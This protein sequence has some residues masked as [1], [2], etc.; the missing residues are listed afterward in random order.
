MLVQHLCYYL[1]DWNGIKPRQE[2]WDTNKV[3]KCLKGEPIKGYAQVTV[4]G[5]NFRLEERNRQGFLDH[6]WSA[7]GRSFSSPNQSTAIVP[8]PNS[9]GVVGAPASYKTLLYAQAIAA[10]SGGKLIA[11]DA[12][13]W[14]AASGAIHKQG[15]ARSPERRFDNLQVIQKPDRPVLL[16]DDFITSGSSFI[17]AVWRLSEVG[18]LPTEGLAVARRTAVQEVKM[19]EYRQQELEIPQKPLF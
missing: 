11:L 16:F 8:I 1:T 7:L 19:F 12:L 5:I 4:A 2:D 10:A 3:V 9:A 13:R 15:G 6:L 17:A 14:K 18:C